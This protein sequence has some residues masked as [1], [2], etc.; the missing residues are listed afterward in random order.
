M[1]KRRLGMKDFASVLAQVRSPD[2]AG[3]F[4]TEGYRKTVISFLRDFFPECPDDI[5]DDQELSVHEGLKMIRQVIAERT[6]LRT[7]S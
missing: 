6:A 2:R 3:D 1:Q 5:K 7:S 4:E